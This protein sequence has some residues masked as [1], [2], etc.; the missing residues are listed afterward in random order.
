MGADS[1][2][3][4]ATNFAVFIEYLEETGSVIVVGL[5]PLAVAVSSFVFSHFS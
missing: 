1:A 4:C 2:A 5:D 3:S